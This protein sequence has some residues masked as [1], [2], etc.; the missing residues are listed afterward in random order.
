[1][2]HYFYTLLVSAA[3]SGCSILNPYGTAG[4]AGQFWCN[5]RYRDHSSWGTETKDAALKGYMYGLAAALVLQ[6]EDPS[7]K[8]ARA[9]YFNR[10]LRLVPVD[11][12]SRTKSGFEVTTFRLKPLKRD[13]DEE[14]VIAFAGS[15][16]RSD[17]FSTNLNPFGKAQ[18]DEAVDY[19]R[20]I[21]NHPTVKGKKIILTGISLGG[22]LVIHVLKQPDIEPYIHEAWALN[23]SPKIYAPEPATE[24]M[25]KKTWMV[26]SE[27]EIL[28]WG[29]SDFLRPLIAG[30]GK[31]EAGA[32]QTAVFK[33]IESN[34]IYAH[35]RW[36]IARQMLWVAD[37][38]ESQ[39][40]R[41][42][43]SEPF[44]I[45][46]ASEFRTCQTQRT[47][48]PIF[49]NLQPKGKSPDYSGLEI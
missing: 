7:D 15:N 19:T 33:L 21:L 47:K 30:A 40:N 43:W 2:K 18:Y 20:R 32:Q 17:W 46:K 49:E 14:I 36:G 44:A 29:R 13:K 9:H 16:D 45:L 37:T 11:T 31:I 4:E 3:L 6:A 24:A 1:M 5:E 38:E 48:Y 8:E 34:R 28:T 23:P 25:R 42:A 22:G 39:N 12:P 41:S 35:Y 27:G 26:Y 10:P